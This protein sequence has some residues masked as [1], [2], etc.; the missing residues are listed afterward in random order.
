MCVAY[1]GS[2]KGYGLGIV[3]MVFGR[4][5]G[6]GFSGAVFSVGVSL[7][8]I[9]PRSPRFSLSLLIPSSTSS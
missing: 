3:L 8:Y 9:A 5:P 2:N 6:L 4:G 7:S 1:R